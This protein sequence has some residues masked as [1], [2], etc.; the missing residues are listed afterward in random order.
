MSKTTH[1]MRD[2]APGQRTEQ[3]RPWRRLHASTYVVLFLTTT[4]LF[5]LNVPGERTI[6]FDG[7]PKPPLIGLT[8]M[9]DRIEHGWPCTYLVRDER[10]GDID[11][12]TGER[13][14]TSLWSFRQDFMSLSLWRLVANFAITIVV[15]LVVALIFDRWRRRRRRIWQLTMVDLLALTAIVAVTTAYGINA[16]R[17]HE[18]ECDA[19]RC[20]RNGSRR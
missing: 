1:I 7:I 8:M 5:L 14:L 4:V 19:L 9:R 20:D 11:P 10:V 6:T 2:R 13:Q 12:V 15:V 17:V 3:S 16:T 18:E